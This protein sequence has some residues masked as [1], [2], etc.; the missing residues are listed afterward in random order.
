MLELSDDNLPHHLRPCFLYFGLFLKDFEIPARQLVRLWIAE[1]FVEKKDG[2]T[3]EEVGEDYL[4]DF[5][6]RNLIQV[7]KRRFDG[8]IKTCCIHDLLH[9]LCIKKAKEDKFLEVLGHDCSSLPLNSRRLGLHSNILKHISSNP[10][11]T[12]L[13]KENQVRHREKENPMLLEKINLKGIP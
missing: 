2:E 5:I 12:K 7:S 1:G 9:D 3:M 6:D 8:T 13:A 10:S 11:A 4:E